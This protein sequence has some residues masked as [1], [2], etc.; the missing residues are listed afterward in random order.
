LDVRPFFLLIQPRPFKWDHSF[1]IG[2]I[3]FYLA[4]YF[5][6]PFSA[7]IFE[8]TLPL[9]LLSGLKMRGFGRIIFLTLIVI[10]FILDWFKIYLLGASNF[11]KI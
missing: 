11:V 6:S 3:I 8:S 10:L 1:E 7:R 2:T 4:T 5:L 9:V